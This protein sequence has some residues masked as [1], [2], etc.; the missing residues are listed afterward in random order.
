M[1][2][3]SG[4]KMESGKYGGSGRW[5]LMN[6]PSG[7]SKPM[8]TSLL[9]HPVIPPRYGQVDR[10]KIQAPVRNKK[11]QMHI[12]KGFED[13]SD[14][15]HDTQ[16]HYLMEQDPLLLQDQAE[17]MDAAAADKVEALKKRKDGPSRAMLKSIWLS[18]LHV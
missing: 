2:W 7:N 6:P 17:V 12:F 8:G 18:V 9:G 14:T 1:G 11:N 4:R 16:T 13:Q 15:Y 5:L 3:M 10:H